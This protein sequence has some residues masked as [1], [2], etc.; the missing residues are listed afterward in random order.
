MAV[1]ESPQEQESQIFELTDQCHHYT[2]I[3]EIEYDI[4]K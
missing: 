4:Q 2:H 1:Q 3:G